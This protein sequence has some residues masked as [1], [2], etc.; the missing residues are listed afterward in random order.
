MIVRLVQ[1][2]QVS[3]CQFSSHPNPGIGLIQAKASPPTP[4]PQGLAGVLPEFVGFV[5]GRTRSPGPGQ[6]SGAAPADDSPPAG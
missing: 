2:C 4:E 5:G 1:G 6:R 3:L